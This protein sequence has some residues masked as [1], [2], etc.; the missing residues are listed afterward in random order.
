MSNATQTFRGKAD[1][2]PPETPTIY[3]VV[4]GLSGVESSQALT[5]GTKQI[6]I[7]TRGLANLQISFVA[8]ESATK[9]IT[10]PK[11]SSYTIGDINFSGTLYFQADKDVQTVEILE[12]ST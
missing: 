1:L 9:F 11:N 8:T 4:T 12:W 5:A 10:I 2:A 3:N 7:R 6:L